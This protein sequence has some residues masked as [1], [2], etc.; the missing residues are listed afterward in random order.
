VQLKASGRYVGGCSGPSS[1]H[2]PNGL[3]EGSTG[4]VV[5]AAGVGD[6]DSVHWAFS[7]K[8]Q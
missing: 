4:V 1:G 2:L 3:L 8:S 7:G 6:L 5:L